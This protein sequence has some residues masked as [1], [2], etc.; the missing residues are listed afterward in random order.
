MEEQA[1]KWCEVFNMNY[2]GTTH[3]GFSC[4]DSSGKVWFVPNY[5]LTKDP[6]RPSVLKPI[7]GQIIEDIVCELRELISGSSDDQFSWGL[8][9]AIDVI[10]NHISGEE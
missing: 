7:A 1:K 6:N 5:I 10:R 3:G 8:Q 4:E 2:I 9:T